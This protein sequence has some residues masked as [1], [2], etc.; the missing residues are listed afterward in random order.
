MWRNHAIR[1]VLLATA[2]CRLVRSIKTRAR[3]TMATQTNELRDF[4]EFLGEKLSNS[5]V[6]LSP[7]EALDEWREQHPESQELTDDVA[8]IKEALDDMANGDA[9]MPFDDFDREFRRRHQLPA[10][11]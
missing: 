11:P 8:A 5:G 2:R 4:H 3:S 1:S 6:S 10:K 7:E 9:G